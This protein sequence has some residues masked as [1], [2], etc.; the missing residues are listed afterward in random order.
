MIRNLPA[1][2]S[3][4]IGCSLQLL[5]LSDMEAIHSGSL[6]VLETIGIKVEDKEARDIFQSGGANVKHE[7]QIVKIPP[8]MVEEALRTKPSKIILAARNP[9]RDLSVDDGRVYFTAF[10]AGVN[11]IDPYTGE[12]RPCK[13]Q[14][15]KNIAVLTDYLDQ[16]DQTVETIVAQDVHPDTVN[17]HCLYENLSNSSKHCLSSPQGKRS[18]EVL[19]EM[20]SIVAG[21]K[22]ELSERPIISGMGCAISPLVFPEG[23]TGGLITYAKMGIPFGL[24]SMVLA[25]GTGPVTL[26]GT[27]V[28]HNAESLAGIVLS[29]LVK[30]GSPVL[31]SSA[32][33]N[34]DMRKAVATVG[35]PEIS[36]LNAALA[37]MARFYKIPSLIISGWTDS[38]V[39]DLQSGHERTQSLLMTMLSGANIIF[40]GGSMDSGLAF[41]YGQYV[42]DNE[43]VRMLKRILKGID[44]SDETMAIDVIRE[45]GTGGEYL[46]H[47]HTFKNLR[48]H[49]MP[50]L[51]NRDTRG[52]WESNGCKN[53]VDNSNAKAIEILETHKPDGLPDNIAGRLDAFMKD[54]DKEFV[55]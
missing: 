17:F 18:A 26:A 34:L 44:V 10:G 30:K 41:H 28:V 51:F 2:Y 46:T 8:Y 14:D 48:L 1:G 25:G 42:A 35:S 45:I 19:L 9:K 12:C 38:K 22:N 32:T 6:E 33:T 24:I 52:I 23:Y 53:L 20:A 13:K 49:E 39:P 21:G 47:E 5:S 40:G 54:I 16:Y 11:V 15:L 50:L 31:Y 55:K 7:T 29:Q 36:L 43:I 4:Y 27:I 3:T 37:K